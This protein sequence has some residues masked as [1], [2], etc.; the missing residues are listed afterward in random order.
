[1]LSQIIFKLPSHL[2][3]PSLAGNFKRWANDVQ[4]LINIP[5]NQS[6]LLFCKFIGGLPAYSMPGSCNE[7]NLPSHRFSSP[8]NENLHQGFQVGVN[9][10]E[11]KQKEIQDNLH[12]S[13]LYF[14]PLPQFLCRLS[15][16][17]SSSKSFKNEL[18]S[19]C[20]WGWP[21]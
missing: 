3:G 6:A 14:S 15:N 13:A 16:V 11:Q 18:Y 1:M 9:D 19:R 2:Y 4:Y 10:D 5:Q 17:P 20:C 8:G 12:G 21:K 7:N